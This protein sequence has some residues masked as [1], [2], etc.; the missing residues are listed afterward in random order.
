LT[1]FFCFSFLSSPQFHFA[2][3]LLLEPAQANNGLADFTTAVAKMEFKKGNF[4][5]LSPRKATLSSEF[6][7]PS[8]MAV[9][10]IANFRAQ[11]CRYGGGAR[12]SGRE[13]NRDRGQ[14]S[15]QRCAEGEMH[16]AAV[17]RQNRN[18]HQRAQ[19]A[20]ERII[21]YRQCNREDLAQCGKV[22]AIQH[23]I[24]FRE[25]APEGGGELA[26]SQGVEREEGRRFANEFGDGG[27]GGNLLETVLGR[28]EHIM[29]RQ[30]HL[31][32]KDSK[33]GMFGRR[34]A[35]TEVERSAKM[36]SSLAAFRDVQSPSLFDRLRAMAGGTTCCI[37]SNGDHLICGIL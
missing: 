32:R 15:C 12:G 14:T 18:G 4:I 6:R 28:A 36:I 24:K 3:V 16:K 34:K 31:Q 5:T 23:F 2:I 7:S 30:V 20:G 25:H 17:G 33:F 10:G 27:S 19:R 21:E 37:T 8:F 22:A 11:K 29:K 13:G 9:S 26:A 35:L 1:F